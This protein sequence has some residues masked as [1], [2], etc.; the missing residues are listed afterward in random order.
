[1]PQGDSL[2][3]AERVLAGRNKVMFL[4]FVKGMLVWRP[5]D[6]MTAWELLEDPWLNTWEING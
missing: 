6:R 5:E 1:M 4:E 3:K 2:E